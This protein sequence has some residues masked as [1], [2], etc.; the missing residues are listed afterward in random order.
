MSALGQ[1]RTRALQHHACLLY[2][3][4][5][6]RKTALRLRETELM[7]SEIHKVCAVF[8][9][10][11]RERGIEADLVGVDAQEPRAN[12]MERPGPDQGIRYEPSRDSLYPAGHFAGGSPRK[13]HK[14][15]A[16]G[17]GT[18]HTSRCATR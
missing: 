13:G 2:S 11:D 16:A 17:I 6:R 8:T 7:P 15:D 14:K 4:R 3:G 10:V 12:P 9:V 18:V 5:W 1:K